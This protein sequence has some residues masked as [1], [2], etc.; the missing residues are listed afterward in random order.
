M[1]FSAVA[2]G[3][4][5]RKNIKVEGSPSLDEC[6]TEGICSQRLFYFVGPAF[7]TSVV[8]G[9]LHSLDYASFH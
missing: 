7:G 2:E 5:D 1:C 9:G 4:Y 8:V 6:F 3:P